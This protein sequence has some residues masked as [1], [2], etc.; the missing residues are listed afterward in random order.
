[1]RD[2]SSGEVLAA[3]EQDSVLSIASVGKLLL[4]VEAARA[5]EEGDLDPGTLLARAEADR[6]A[7][8]GLWQ[9]LGVDALPAA[10]VAALVGAFSDNLATNVLLRH[11]G[12][13]RVAATAA[14]LGLRRT[15]LHDRVRDVRGPDD[16]PRLASGTAGELS[17]LLAELFAGRPAASGLVRGWLSRNA[18]LSMV[19]AALGLDPLAHAADRGLRLRNKTGTDAGVRADAGLLA[20]PLGAVAYAV[21]A[22][23]DEGERRDEVLAAM[24]RVGRRLAVA[25]TESPPSTASP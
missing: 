3:R 20:G 7:D 19:P 5:I 21:V 14:A 25:V 17:R 8:S 13:E 15:A 10:D 1:M 6:V 9:D 24:A 23:W 12:L 2:A 22:N 11:L 4:L 16:P 18:D